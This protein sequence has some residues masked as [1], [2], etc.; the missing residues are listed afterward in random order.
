MRYRFGLTGISST[1][2]AVAGMA[3]VLAGSGRVVAEEIPSI[4]M[5]TFQSLNS[6]APQVA[7]EKGFFD[8]HGIK[9]EILFAPNSS[10]QRNGLVNGEF[11]V[12]HTSADNSVSLVEERQV[13]SIIVMGGDDA[14]NRMIAQ[15]D[16]DSRSDLRG[17]TIAVDSPHTA[18]ALLFYRALRN[19][20]LEKGDYEVRSVG[21]TSARAK[22]MRE[23]R[24]NAAALLSPPFTFQAV[25]AGLKDLGPVPTDHS[26][27]IVV[28]R[29][30]ANANS[31]AMVRYL[32]GVI[33]GRRWLLDRANKEEAIGFLQKRLKLSHDMASRSYALIT[34][35]DTGFD[36]DG[37]F[38]MQGFRN[39]LSLRA[40]TFEPWNGRAPEPDKFIDLTHYKAALS[41]L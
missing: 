22:A 40:E 10:A 19:A 38:N 17:R 14:F 9:V 2:C 23:D 8:K 15:S 3:A 26:A 24:S 30:W 5:M 25:D 1:L 6:L 37:T 4:K 28:M 7:Q 20:G 13:D 35:P 36:P 34:D 21:G 29:D 39:V 41:G 27:A 18:F 16:V 11:Q 33:E 31:E 12:I 32:R